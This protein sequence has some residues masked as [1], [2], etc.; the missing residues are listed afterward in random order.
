MSKFVVTGSSS[1]E[2]IIYRTVASQSLRNTAIVYALAACTS[3]VSCIWPDDGS[4]ET[5]HVAEFLILLP[6]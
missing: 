5:K 1:Y 6:I 4:T 3:T 2:K